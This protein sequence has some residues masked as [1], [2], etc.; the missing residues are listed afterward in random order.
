MVMKSNYRVLSIAALVGLA[1]L[2]ATNSAQANE[3]AEIPTPNAINIAL[4]TPTHGENAGYTLTEITNKTD[5]SIT[6]YEVINNETKPHYYQYTIKD[7]ASVGKYQNEWG[8][9]SGDN[10]FERD[11]IG[12]DWDI[13]NPTNKFKYCW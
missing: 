5:S 1:G 7:G 9:A 13:Y 11:F 12:N 2:G 8:T 4:P 6:L 3:I 10:N